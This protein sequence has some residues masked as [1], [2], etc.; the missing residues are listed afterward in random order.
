MTADKSAKIQQ[1]NKPLKHAICHLILNLYN[2]KL[3]IFKVTADNE[4][5]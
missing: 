3:K 5:K 2:E 4:R 1:K